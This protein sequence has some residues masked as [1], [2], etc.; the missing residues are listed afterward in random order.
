ML[1]LKL[2]IEASRHCTA[3]FTENLFYKLIKNINLSFFYYLNLLYI[4]FLYYF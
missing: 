2:I 1:N 3:G 4:N